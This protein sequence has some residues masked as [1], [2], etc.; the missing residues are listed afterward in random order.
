MTWTGNV[1]ILAGGAISWTSR[2]QHCVVL[3]TIESKF[4]ALNEVAKEYV[5]LQKLSRETSQ[6]GYFEERHINIV[7]Q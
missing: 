2:K 7:N 3:S 5:F 6:N 1:F 4:V